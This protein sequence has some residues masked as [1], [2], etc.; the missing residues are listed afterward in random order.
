M[1]HFKRGTS[2]NCI[3]RSIENGSRLRLRG[4]V[5]EQDL[6]ESWNYE[7][8]A[9]RGPDQT[10]HHSLHAEFLQKYLLFLVGFHKDGIPAVSINSLQFSFDIQCHIE[11]RWLPA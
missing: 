6:R 8:K 3:V 5:I 2:L 7:T 10:D 1:G 4:T 11:G 9:K